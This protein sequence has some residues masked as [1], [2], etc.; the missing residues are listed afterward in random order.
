MSEQPTAPDDGGGEAEIDVP[1]GTVDRITFEILR[2]GSI[3]LIVFMTLLI[4]LEAL[5][6]TLIGFSIFGAHDIIGLSLILMFLLALPYSWAGDYHV[7]MDMLYRSY[8]PVPRFLTDLVATAGALAFGGFIAWQAWIYVPSFMKIGTASPLLKIPYW[9][10][11]AAIFA[12][13]TLFC[14]AV[15][16]NMV[17]RALRLAKGSD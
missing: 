7:R 1:R 14:L 8:G 16:Y 11:A 5:L 2:W 12:F 9:P 6:R 15:A 17:R 4:G 10:L 13:A 3:V